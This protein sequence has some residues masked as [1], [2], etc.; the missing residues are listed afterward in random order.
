MK[1]RLW[2]WFNQVLEP[3]P[4]ILLVLDLYVFPK[5]EAEPATLVQIGIKWSLGHCPAS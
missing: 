3:F 4:W 5:T 2:F 1:V